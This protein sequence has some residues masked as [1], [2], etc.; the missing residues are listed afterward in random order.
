MRRNQLTACVAEEEWNVRYILGVIS[1]LNMQT[2][3]YTIISSVWELS[4][5]C[6]TG[7]IL[8]FVILKYSISWIMPG[9]FL[10]LFCMVSLGAQKGA[11][12]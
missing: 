4:F 12:K 6:K 9:V 10:N 2:L 3:L 5:R 1:N 8:T 7:P 11:F